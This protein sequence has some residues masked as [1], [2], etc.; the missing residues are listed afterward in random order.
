MSP[1]GERRWER[2]MRPVRN[3]RPHQKQQHSLSPLEAAVPEATSHSPKHPPEDLGD[4]LGP[5]GREEHQEEATHDEHHPSQ[6]HAFKFDMV[7]LDV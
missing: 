6:L 4:V 5:V 2:E 3:S 1:E 7:P